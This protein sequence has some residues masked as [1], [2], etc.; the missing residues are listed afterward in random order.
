MATFESSIYALQKPDR[1]NPVRLPAPNIAG[2]GVQMAVVKYELA[3]TEAHGTSD[4][5]NLCILP[6]GAIPI[7]GLS[8]VDCA[9]PGTTLAVD[10]GYASNPDALADGI[11]L[12]SGGHVLFTSG[13]MPADA[14][15]P[16][17]LASTDTTIY[18][19]VTNASTLTASADLVFHIAY[20]IPA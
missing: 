8:F 14:L 18:A 15:T 10:I 6:T 2:G 20:K 16:A 3:G 1:V 13:T 7:P 17:A 4:T 19:T 11:T 12:S 5:I 9:D